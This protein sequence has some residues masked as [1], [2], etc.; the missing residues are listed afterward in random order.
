MNSAGAWD[1][2]GL[3]GGRAHNFPVRRAAP[4]LH[5]RAR[6]ARPP[7]ATFRLRFPG[8][9]GLRRRLA[10]T[11]PHAPGRA[12]AWGGRS[13]A[14]CRDR[15]TSSGHLP[16]PH[17]ASRQLGSGA[18]A[19]PARLHSRALLDRGRAPAAPLP[20][21]VGGPARSRVRGA[22]GRAGSPRGWAEFGRPGA[23][24]EARGVPPRSPP[25]CAPAIGRAFAPCPGCLLAAGGPPWPGRSAAAP[26]LPPESVAR[27][28]AHPAGSAAGERLARERCRRASARYLGEVKL[29]THRKPFRP[30]GAS[31][32]QPEGPPG[33]GKS[34]PPGPPRTEP[35]AGRFG[36][37][38]VPAGNALAPP[39]ASAPRPD[40]AH[41]QGPAAPGAR[42]FNR[43]RGRGG[44][45]MGGE[46][47]GGSPPALT[48]C[49]FLIS[50]LILLIHPIL[51]N[52]QPW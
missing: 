45:G 33:R 8:G 49:F 27:T 16:A 39:G 52:R 18:R 24:P 2:T 29:L 1:R 32:L 34:R 42:A 47:E 37:A 43:G 41:R 7:P 9:R 10:E 14:S 4:R 12:Q 48:V 30:L 36:A 44:G 28:R 21:P 25:G 22:G 20:V 38:G 6:G 3:A 11:Q 46:E 31:R 23:P 26:P 50:I 5:N 35:G 51:I 19:A 15:S 17:L 40:S 13:P